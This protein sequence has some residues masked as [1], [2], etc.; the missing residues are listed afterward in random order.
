[1]WTEV[2]PALHYSVIIVNMV[3]DIHP[4]HLQNNSRLSSYLFV[5]IQAEDLHKI[6]AIRHF[7]SSKVMAEM[8]ETTSSKAK[9]VAHRGIKPASKSHKSA[10]DSCLLILLYVYLA[11]REKKN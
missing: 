4:M 9:G 1:M 7:K 8:N 11:R 5:E 3:N 6:Y 2:K 10:H